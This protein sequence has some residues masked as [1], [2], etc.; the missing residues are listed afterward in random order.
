M[1][2]V[3][4]MK[5]TVLEWES[6]LIDVWWPLLRGNRIYQTNQVNTVPADFLGIDSDIE[7][8]FL[9]VY[10]QPPESCKE[11]FELKF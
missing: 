9:E 10:F 1:S 11:W 8:I 3:Y 5:T 4:L 6:W 2:D 7:F